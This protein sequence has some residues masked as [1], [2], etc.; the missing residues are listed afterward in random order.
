MHEFIIHLHIVILGP[1]GDY[2]L[3]MG[4]D[5]GRTVAEQHT[6]PFI[7]F[8]NV[9]AAHK[10]VA[11]HRVADP[12]L[13]QMSIAETDPLGGK[14]ARRLQ[15]GHEVSG[16]SGC[17]AGRLGADKAVGGDLDKT[18]VGIA[19]DG[20][21]LYDVIQHERIGIFTVEDGVFIIF[22]PCLQGMVVL[23]NRFSSHKAS[24]LVVSDSGE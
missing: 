3:D 13:T 24:F 16:E 19:G 14:L 20:G 7:T 9:E 2:A 5:A 15:Q 6:E 23:F 22:L 12:F 11:L 18:E 1:A 17:A 10:F 4:G 8:L 21:F